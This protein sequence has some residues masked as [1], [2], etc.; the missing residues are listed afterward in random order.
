[1]SP[2]ESPWQPDKG[3]AAKEDIVFQDE[4]KIEYKRRIT[5]RKGME[6]TDKLNSPT[7]KIIT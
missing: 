2:E 1:M 3:V 6:F 4:L 7:Y 5:Q